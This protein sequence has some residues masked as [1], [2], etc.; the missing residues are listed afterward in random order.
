VLAYVGHASAEPGPP[1]AAPETSELESLYREH[2]GFVWRNAR[3]L[4]CDEDWADDVVHEVFLVAHR[5]LGDFEYRSSVRTWLFAITYRVIQRMRRDRAR[6]DRRLR[7]YAIEQVP[8]TEPHAR[9][10][11]SDYLRHLLEQL[12]EP[13]RVVFIL[14]E[15]EGM[16]SVEIGH[17]LGVKPPTVDSRRR[18]ARL[19]LVKML[20]RDR[21]REGSRVT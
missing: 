15:L 2:H 21:A 6:R 8:A 14:A 10:E 20:K 13:K 11:A 16:S 7:A 4:G 19:Q 5:K 12:D 3:R 18:A 9:S 17:C 1:A